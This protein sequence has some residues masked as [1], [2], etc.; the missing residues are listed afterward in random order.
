MTDL[1]P[2]LSVVIP[3]FNEAQRLR[4]TLARV[5][6]FLDASARSYELLVVDDG[7]S[8]ATAL[9]AGELVGERG[10]VIAL[11]RNRGKGAAVRA[12]VLASRGARVLVTDADLS[13]PIE[14][15]AKL[16]AVLDAGAA[17]AVASRAVAGA[18]LPVRQGPLRA[19]IGRGFN[20]FVRA[21]GLSPLLDTQCGFKLF[22]GEAARSLFAALEIEGFAFDVEV[23]ARAERAGLRVVELPVLWRNDADSRVRAF[24]GARAF[25]DLAQIWRGFAG[26]DWRTPRATER[27]LVVALFVVLAARWIGLGA[28]PVLDTSEARYAAIAQGMADSGD[29]V[30]P[31]L[32]GGEPFWAKPPLHFWLTAASIRALGANEFAVRLPCAL[33]ELVLIA[34]TFALGLLA[35]NRRTALLAAVLVASMLLTLGLSALA[36]TDMTLA[37]CVASAL[38]CFAYAVGL[39]EREPSWRAG[40]GFF[41]CLGL[42]MLAKG[43]VALAICGGAIAIYSLWQRSLAWL[44]RLPWLTGTLVFCAV[45]APWYLLAEARTPGFLDYFLVHEN[46]LRFVSSSYGDRY[47]DNH[48]YPYGTIWAFLLLGTLP[49]SGLLLFGAASRAPRPR[50]DTPARRFVVAC[51][52]AAPLFFTPARNVVLSYV[53][54]SLPGVAL[55]AALFLAPLFEREVLSAGAQRIERAA[56][57]LARSI[58]LLA[59]AAGAF[60]MFWLGSSWRDELAL[61]LLFPL[62]ALPILWLGRATP[63]GG[64]LATCIMLALLDMTARYVVADELAQQRSAR[65]LARALSARVELA[66]CGVH[67]YG[68]VPLSA[69]FYLDR[70]IGTIGKQRDRLRR[71]RSDRSCDVF[72]LHP[73]EVAHLKRRD[74]FALALL[75]ERGPYVALSDGEGAASQAV[76]AAPR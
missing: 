32:P 6:A 44:P 75:F 52:V 35:A 73:K 27:I 34:A 60:A 20:R 62:A 56:I 18:E 63:R 5:M 14:Q 74:R 41:A 11:G 66:S 26:S 70:E 19:A 59:V 8:D 9:V 37:A 54:P 53:M 55:V 65:S 3:A 22:E 30:T 67:F 36:I 68:L 25:A 12:G 1:R 33:G 64:V 71:E 38:S 50:F 61:G 72:M 15:L 4:P 13:T 7:S 47:G 2:S 16:E 21:L 48:S 17:V 45:A 76:S 24:A 69:E 57:W 43:P 31:R 49:W 58:P 28:L 10:R 39:G 23:L 51:A 46:F 40:L 29:W 42:G